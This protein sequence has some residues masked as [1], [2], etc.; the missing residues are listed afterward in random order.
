MISVRQ[1][2]HVASAAQVCSDFELNG[3][4]DWFLP[5]LDELREW[6]WNLQGVSYRIFQTQ[7]YNPDVKERIGGRADYFY[8]SST[9]LGAMYYWRL[10]ATDGATL[11]VFKTEE[12]H[13]VAVRRF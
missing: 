11:G 8:A 2:G 3:Y 9:E 1:E 6:C 5:S 10:S 13:F 4:G 7:V 12:T